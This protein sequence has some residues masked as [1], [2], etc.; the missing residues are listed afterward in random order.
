MSGHAWSIH[1][2][3]M[4]EACRVLLFIGSPTGANN[5]ATPE[6]QWGCLAHNTKPR[7]SP[8]GIDPKDAHFSPLEY[9]TELRFIAEPPVAYSAVSFA[10]Q[11]WSV[12]CRWMVPQPDLEETHCLACSS[13]NGCVAHLA[14][15]FECFRHAS[16]RVCRPLEP[17]YGAAVMPLQ[18]ESAFLLF[19]GRAAHEQAPDLLECQQKLSDKRF[20]F[21]YHHEL[22]DKVAIGTA[23]DT[24]CVLPSFLWV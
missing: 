18:K 19:G 21:Q 14:N 15:S 5:S 12:G 4:W 11:E 10:A 2:H 17:L 6:A 8:L 9:S 16:T 13:V 23:N 3:L 22:E 20:R 7:P 24:V 1:V